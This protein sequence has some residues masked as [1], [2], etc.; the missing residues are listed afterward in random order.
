MFLF[1]LLTAATAATAAPQPLTDSKSFAGWEG[2]TTTTW[3]IE[4]GAFAAGSLTTTQPRNEFLC[5]VK[6]YG[7]FDL[8]LRWKLE[9]TEG[10]VNGG[11]QF[12]S[13]RVPDH[14]EVCGYQ[15]DIGMK[16]DG[17]LYDESRRNKMLAQPAE[18]VRIR[19]LKPGAW[20]DYRIRAEG[21]RI[22]IWLNDQLTVDYTEQDPAIPQRG[23]IALQIH[24]GAK[25][26]VWYRDVTIEELTP[27]APAPGP[28]Q[29][30]IAD[31]RPS[32]PRVAFEQGKFVIREDEVIAFLGGE[33]MV[34]LMAQG[35]LEAAL[36]AG[37]AAQRPRF[38]SM[39]WEGDT[40]Y[41]QWRD[42]NFGSW[43]E[44]LDAV[45]ASCVVLWF[46]QMEAM[47]DTRDDTAFA[48]ASAALLD[49]LRAVTPRLVVVLPMA[50]DAGPEPRQGRPDNTERND[51]IQSLGEILRHQATERGAL[52]ADWPELE[53]NLPA[54]P[55]VRTGNGL[56]LTDSAIHETYAPMLARAAGM[57]DTGP[58]GAA[59]L[60]EI[61][62]KNR[63]W[64]DC[65]KAMNWAF[66]YSDRTTQA[67]GQAAGGHPSLVQ[68]LEQYRV[69]LR[70]AD[71]RIQALAAG[72]PLP[73][74][75]PAAAETPQPLQPPQQ[76][77][78][79]FRIREGFAV[80]LFASE[81]D[82]LVKPLSMRWDERGRLWAA[83]SP[84]YPQLIPGVP[85]ND[86]I[87]ICED[88]D[89]DGRADKFTR[90]ASGLTM[91][92]GLEF[93]AGGV[94]VCESTQLVHYA[95]GQN[96]QCGTRTVVLSGFGT[97]DSHQMINSLR[98]GP[99]GCLWFSQGL[100]IFSRIETPHGASRLDRAGLWRYDPRTG[101]LDSFFGNAA[102]GANCWG[103]TFDN[104][105]QVFHCAADNTPGFYTTPGL[106]A[107]SI[108]PPY[109]GIGALATSRVKGM[110][111]EYIDST[112]LP[113]ALQ[114]VLCKPVYLANEVLTW[115][116]REDGSGYTTG[117]PETLISSTQTAFRP[118][119]VQTGPDGALYLCDWYNPVIGHYQASYRD[120]A[121]DK[122]HGRIW[123]ITA[124]GRPLAVRPALES[125]DTAGLI[126][127][128]RSP[129]RWVRDHASRL[130]SVKNAVSE[131]I[132]AAL[133]PDATPE[134]L[135]QTLTVLA[136]CSSTD[137][138]LMGLCL[139][140]PHPGLR[141]FAVRLYMQ[142]NAAGI[143]PVVGA[144]DAIAARRQVLL[145]A[146]ND[147]HPRV[148]LEGV[149]AASRIPLISA[150]ETAC[151]V[152]EYPR[153]RFLDYA[154]GNTITSLWPQLT[155]AMNAGEVPF[156]GSM[157]SFSHVLR[158]HAAED[159][160]LVRQAL[161]RTDLPDASREF[162]RTL[163]IR[164]GKPEEMNAALA[165]GPLT[166]AIIT[167]L[168]ART[169]AA[170]LPLPEIVSK[171]LPAWLESDPQLAWPVILAWKL[172]AYR[173][174]A[175]Q[176]ML[177][178]HAA[179][180]AAYAA[181]AG[182]ESLPDLLTQ[183]NSSE[184]K[185]V[186][187]LL[188]AIASVDMEEAARATAGRRLQGVTNVFLDREGGSAALGRAIAASPPDA[189]WATLLM[190]DV[191]RAGRSDLELLNALRTAAGL[192]PD[193]VPAWSAELVARLLQQARDSGSAELGRT[194]FFQSPA[195][196]AGCHMVDGNGGL[197]GPD[198]STISR[199]LS[200]ELI[201]ESLYWPSRQIKE[202]YSLTT[203]T[204]KDGS[205][206]SGY[207]ITED[208]AQLLLQLPGTRSSI[209]L[210]KDQIAHR[211]ADRSLMPEG[212]V[213][214]LPEAQRINLLRFLLDAGR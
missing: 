53:K 89:H 60:T 82:G 62:R 13:Q 190:E 201:V 203:V 102:A 188:S 120:P 86:Y 121:R 43:R 19:A 182:R 212:L 41:E 101:K 31:D 191:H 104:W 69:L 6:E 146:V 52:V 84:S 108:P 99:D 161:T 163:I 36:T 61:H 45:Q 142:Q 12:R 172:D 148:R 178:G 131:V 171:Q 170:P 181:L 156:Q 109:Y 32:P 21:P 27:A 128:L 73:P 186:K 149:L 164:N 199:S 93:G 132:A 135:Y 72:Q 200:P 100:H 196:C 8:R 107:L 9:G 159:I 1:C 167:S 76:E 44:Q 51:R 158:S 117:E 49:E 29:Q 123:R 210:R 165:D 138:R 30:R 70:D 175:R 5:T 157:E 193:T 115:P 33:N 55:A 134:F 7:D 166:G 176:D 208:A 18:D 192:A 64:H 39:A 153:D 90:F 126:A 95:I 10:F 66:A 130:L 202:G 47:D 195:A 42:L 54:A 28:V 180:T 88:T 2:D 151:A 25:S 24:G 194:V 23:K 58:L 189:A 37:A 118:V 17:A 198:L 116:L 103:V 114:G 125:M 81:S 145:N 207:R 160:S 91:P 112:H 141:A 59:L 124:Q 119:A 46:G 137:E 209:T 56:H 177:R 168:T 20:N 78:D 105:G 77:Q 79:S 205:I 96:D 184:N 83:C 65:W 34:R 68:A 211:A 98:W 206:T 179:A 173:D 213:S 155:A 3:R 15:A 140:H 92:M 106:G 127:A 162:L 187:H 147:S 80:N 57:A 4:D 74:P 75:L 154:L 133:Q 50:M 150:L 204:G 143:S 183:L 169:A 94:Y 174:R 129:E 144:E 87:L 22:R 136:A 185:D 63:L 35:E 97:G 152:L 197:T 38:R 40:V 26:L 113:P 139:S 85:P 111:M 71:A 48:T 67:F 14:Y 110:C 122:V 214:L 16:Y 11:V